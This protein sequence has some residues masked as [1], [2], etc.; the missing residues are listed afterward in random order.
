M[1]ILGSIIF[2]RR[3]LAVSFD[4]LKVY[5]KLLLA[6]TVALLHVE[7]MTETRDGRERSLPEDTSPS[8][9]TWA[10]VGPSW[11]GRIMS[12]WGTMTRENEERRGISV[13]KVHLQR[14]DVYIHICIGG[15]PRQYKERSRREKTYSLS[16]EKL[17]RIKCDRKKQGRVAMGTRC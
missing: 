17:R 10:C 14:T 1:R 12:G 8:F 6:R 4:V 15:R 13:Y 2:R 3:I 9:N 11:V 7:G 16:S 5:I